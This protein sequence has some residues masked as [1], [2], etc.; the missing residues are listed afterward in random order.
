M[1]GHHYPVE[2]RREAVEA[3]VAAGKPE[4]GDMAAA[5]RIFRERVAAASLPKNPSEFVATWVRNWVERS[6]VRSPSPA[7]RQSAISD[8]V[9]KECVRRLKAGY[10]LKG[11]HK[12][13]RSLREAAKYNPYIKSVL[14]SHVD[15]DSGKGLTT[16]TLWR[17]L[18]MVEPTLTRRTL[19]FA[20]KLTA[21]HKTARVQYCQKL[22]AMSPSLRKQYLARVVWIDSKK[23]YVVP[24]GRQVYAPADANML[25]QDPRIPDSFSKVK[26]IMYYAAVNAAIGPVLWKP[27]TGTTGDKVNG[28][29]VYPSGDKRYKASGSE[30]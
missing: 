25:V 4:P 23:L 28:K 1:G 13:Y 26:K 27:V 19:R 24:A 22:L 7:P 16:C 20:F 17:R 2:V 5:V 12:C 3:W 9:A 15:P 30:S 21:A 11:Q 14:E 29:L 18:K 10:M 6:S 8:D